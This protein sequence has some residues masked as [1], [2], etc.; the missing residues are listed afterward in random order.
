MWCFCCW[1]ANSTQSSQRWLHNRAKQP[2]EWDSGTRQS[3]CAADS[4]T[5]SPA[6]SSATWLEQCFHR[7]VSTSNLIRVLLKSSLTYHSCFRM[8][9]RSL[10]LP[11][12]MKV[13]GSPPNALRKVYFMLKVYFTCWTTLFWFLRGFLLR[14]RYNSYLKYPMWD[15]ERFP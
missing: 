15:F 8:V 2:W 3:Q 13:P 9:L 7:S 10:Q 11:V 5:G 4:N 6:H 14:G 12:G 1:P